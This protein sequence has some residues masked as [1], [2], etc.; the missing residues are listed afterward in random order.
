MGWEGHALA[1]GV[2]G[3]EPDNAPG[4]PP[5]RVGPAPVPNAEAHAAG[6]LAA[7]EGFSYRDSRGYFAG[8]ADPARSG[9]A[10]EAAVAGSIAQARTQTADALVIHVISHGEVKEG[11]LYLHGGDTEKAQIVVRGW[12]EEAEGEFAQVRPHTLFVLDFCYAGLAAHDV[13]IELNRPPG[14]R[15]VWVIA[16][17]RASEPAFSGNLTK[18]LTKVLKDYSSGNQRI[19]GSLP[20]I[21][22]DTVVYDV[23][24]EL[25]RLQDGSGW[26]QQIEASRVELGRAAELPFFPNP[27]PPSVEDTYLSLRVDALTRPLLDTIPRIQNRPLPASAEAGPAAAADPVRVLS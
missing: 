21:P 27:T 26:R 12:L 4:E 25:D 11:R 9:S 8:A 6:L 14:E 24:R 22:L 15:R 3:P 2:I 18:A 1:V 13:W 19:N 23:K 16:A 17:S 10:L 5:Q 20:Y 7:L